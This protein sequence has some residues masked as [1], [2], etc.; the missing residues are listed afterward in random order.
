M[1]VIG[2][3]IIGLTCAWRLNQAGRTVEVYDARRCGQEASWAAAG[4]LAPG[5][6]VE[7]ES[8]LAQMMLASRALYPDFVEELRR[9]SGLPIDFRPCGALE[10]AFDD[11]EAEHL[12]HKAARQREFGIASEPATHNGRYARFYPDDALVDPRHLVAALLAA[13]RKRGVAIHEFR[14]VVEIAPDAASFQLR[15][16]RIAA[17]DGILLAAGAWSSAV[18]PALPETIP[19]K[20][21]IASWKLAPGLFQPILRNAHTYVMQRSNGTV[22][23]GS[24]E[25]HVGFNRRIRKAAVADLHRR[26]ARLLPALADRPPDQ[27][28]TGFRPGIASDQPF[29]GRIGA[30]LAATGHYRNGILLAPE[31]ATRL[32]HSLR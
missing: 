18:A 21:H 8:P 1:I 16:R 3:G 17:P 27:A 5:G 14:R 30:L 20:G 6:E 10:V 12:D 15:S 23:A 28:W 2:G 32:L 11:A 9:E 26:A 24:N 31:T 29:L 22:I 4:M 13:L 7:S 25:E 19:V